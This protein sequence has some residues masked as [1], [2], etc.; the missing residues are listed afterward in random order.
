MRRATRQSGTKRRGIT[1]VE[2]LLASIVTALT[3]TAGATVLYAVSSSAT[4]TRE[5]R[6]QRAGGH[7]AL[8]RIGRTVRESRAIVY[9]AS[10]EIA[11]WL[12]DWNENDAVDKEELGRIIYDN[13]MQHIRFEYYYDDGTAAPVSAAPSNIFGSRTSMTTA[14]SGSN[15]KSVV[16][17]EGVTGAIFS[18]YKDNVEARVVLSEFTI[19]ADGTSL[20]FH[21]AASPR[22]PGD[23]LFFED[24]KRAPDIR[25]A[26]AKRKIVSKWTGLG[27]LTKIVNYILN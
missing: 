18:G 20:L 4:K 7:Y 9:V 26:R 6:T 3:A 1:L 2:L 16:W 5:Y 14:M 8:D 27:G 25:S 10:D 12:N 13:S 15:V 22:A 19:N 11:L 21:K 23:Y 24:T 17:V